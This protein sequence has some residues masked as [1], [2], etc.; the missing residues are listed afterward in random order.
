MWNSFVG[1]PLVGATQE[2]HGLAPTSPATFLPQL[3]HH[4]RPADAASVDRQS[5]SRASA[6]GSTCLDASHGHANE[7]LAESIFESFDVSG[8][9]HGSPSRAAQTPASMQQCR[10]RTTVQP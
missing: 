5:T 8:R 1:C 9:P 4:M 7:G 3:E 10:D 6:S 2:I